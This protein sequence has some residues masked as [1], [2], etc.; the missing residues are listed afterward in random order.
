MIS[1][2]F[3]PCRAVIIVTCLW[4]CQLLPAQEPRT[5]ATADAQAM[6][7]WY[8]F[9]QRDADKSY[10]FALEP[11][12]GDLK[13]DLKPI[14][15]WT[16]PLEEGSIHGVVYV[17]RTAGRP[18][19]VGQLFSYLNGK[20]DRVYCHAMHSLARDGEKVTGWRNGKVF[21]TPDSPGVEMHDLPDGPAPAMTRPARL[22]QMREI[23]RRFAAYT[24]EATRGKRVLRLL[25]TPLDRFPESDPPGVDG[26]VFSFVVGNDPEVM[27][28]VEKDDRPAAGPIWRYGLIRSTRST[29]VAQLDEREVWRY[30][31][32]DKNPADPRGGYLSVHGIATLPLNAPSADQ[33]DK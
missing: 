7:A 31:S 17:W 25:P 13:L 26:A 1:F 9:Y 19:V 28:L 21:W 10:R 3:K 29:A 32:A 11:G 22:V 2:L 18:V 6:K 14:L 15:R 12:N 20:G 8:A 24:E 4:S 30:D 16:N 27:L 5:E 33:N 23:T